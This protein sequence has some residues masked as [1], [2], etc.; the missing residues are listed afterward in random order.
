MASILKMGYFVTDFAG[1]SISAFIRD[2]RVPSVLWYGEISSGHISIS[3]LCVAQ[4]ERDKTVAWGIAFDIAD[5]EGR[6][7]PSEIWIK[8]WVSRVG[9]SIHINDLLFCYPYAVHATS[10]VVSESVAKIFHSVAFL[11]LQEGASPTVATGGP[12][13]RYQC[14]FMYTQRGRNIARV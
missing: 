2:D 13:D 10:T 12:R 11:V 3:V 6:A 5:I 9:K 4:H 7:I 14:W 8:P 1:R